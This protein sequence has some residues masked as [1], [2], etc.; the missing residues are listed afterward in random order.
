[1]TATFY[2]K[3][4]LSIVVIC[5]FI[6]TGCSDLIIEEK[7]INVVFRMDDPSATSSTETELR[8]IDAFREHNVSITFGIVPFICSGDVQDTAPHDVVPLGPIKGRLLRIWIEEGVL[9]IALH[10][11]SHQTIHTENYAEFRDL[12]YDSQL[13]KLSKGKK[14]LEK[15]IGIPV[16]TFVPPWNQYDLNTLKALEVLG[17]T[18]LSAAI[19]GKVSKDSKLNFIPCTSK[20]SEL[21]DAIKEARASSDKQPLI[22]V[23]FHQYDFQEVR[24]KRGSITIKEFNNLFV[25][26]LLKSISNF[27]LGKISERYS[28]TIN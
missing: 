23:L 3:V 17:F 8:V 10:G 28:Y 4:F 19:P 5:T 2:H 6:F 7:Q 12:D 18:T 22:V 24:N 15:M 27:R 9:D 11:Y 13:E 1:M 26:F 16:T 20:L 14:L 21:H 25:F